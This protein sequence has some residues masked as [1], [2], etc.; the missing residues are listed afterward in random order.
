MSNRRAFILPACLLLVALAAGAQ[1]VSIPS[2]GSAVLVEE[3][4]HW[5]GHVVRFTGEAIGEAQRRGDMAWIHL[6][7]DAYGL[8]DAGTNQALAGFNS[9]IAVWVDSAMAF[10]IASFGDYRRHGDLI[11]ATGTF[12]AACPQ[13][14]GDMD[15]HATS[16]LVV[17]PGYASVQLIRPSRMIA[18]SILAVLT[19]GMFLVN[20]LMD[21]R[22]KGGGLRP[23]RGRFQPPH[24][25]TLGV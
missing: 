7:D 23:G 5:D 11:E 4:Q 10:R 13:H 6:N 14:G 3:A 21:R 12:N 8:A 16:L 24:R 20:L 9:G 22:S 25:G 2:P 15:I 17:R 1:Q 18:A 19:L